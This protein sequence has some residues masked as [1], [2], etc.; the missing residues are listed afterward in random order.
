VVG[1]VR[2]GAAAD[3]VRARVPATVGTVHPIGEG[4]CDLVAGADHVDVLA[5]HLAGVA[6]GL[7]A[8]LEVIEPGALAQAM[9]RVGS[10]VR[11][12]GGAQA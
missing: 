2:I 3:A 4:S 10:R 1:R 8:D 6:L 5:W 11:R 12:F 7:D 9:R